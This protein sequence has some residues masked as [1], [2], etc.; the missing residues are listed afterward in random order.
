MPR[1]AGLVTA[2]EQSRP[3]ITSKGQPWQVERSLVVG[4]SAF[5]FLDQI[6]RSVYEFGNG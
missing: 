2:G 4:S 6:K 1:K 3:Q 5:L